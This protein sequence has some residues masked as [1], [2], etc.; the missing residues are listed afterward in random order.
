MGVRSGG[1][2]GFCAGVR[3]GTAGAA[4]AAGEFSADSWLDMAGFGVAEA[5]EYAS[6]GRFAAGIQLELVGWIDLLGLAALGTFYPLA[7]GSD[8]VA[9]CSVVFGTAEGAGG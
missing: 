8:R 4:T 1:F 7:G 3:P 9:V 6:V 5:S 2:S